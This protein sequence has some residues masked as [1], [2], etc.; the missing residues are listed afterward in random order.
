M[1]ELA[2]PLLNMVFS[3]AQLAI[4]VLV[5]KRLS[6]PIGY[7]LGSSI[8]AP[9]ESFYNSL[10]RECIGAEIFRDAKAAEKEIFSYIECYYNNK[11]KHSALGY[12]SPVK[13]EEKYEKSLC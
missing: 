1:I 8:N 11:R 3:C 12:L 4:S 9:M 7:W 13:F 5:I 6:Q 10:K 2:G